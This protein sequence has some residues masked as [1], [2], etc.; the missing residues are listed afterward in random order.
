[1]VFIMNKLSKKISLMITS[2]ILSIATGI[3][4]AL[5][6]SNQALT[7]SSI[8]NIYSKNQATQTSPVIPSEVNDQNANISTKNGPVTFLGNK[9]TALDWFGNK[10][11]E[12]DF[13]TLVPGSQGVNGQSYNGAWPRAWFNWD[14]NR[15]TDT[16][17][18]LGF[19][20]DSTKTQPLFEIKAADGSITNTHT[21]NY[22]NI[23]GLESVKIS[24]AY[25]F[26][27][28]LSSGK[29][30]I[31]GGAGSSY[32]GKAILYDPKTKTASLLNGNSSSTEILPMGDASHGS[33]Y[34]WYFFN[35]IPVAANRNIVEVVT[36]ANKETSNDEGS[37]Y[38]NYHVYFL[39]VD[40]Q[41]N[42]VF[43]SSSS[44]GSQWAKPV[45]V[46]DG[47]QGYRNSKITPQ[48]DYYSLLDGRVVTVVYNT[49]IIIDGKSDNVQVGVYPTSQS[50]WIKS[51]AFDSNQNLYFKFKNEDVIYK[52][53]GSSWQTINNTNTN[54]SPYVYLDLKGISA[55]SAYAQDLIIYNVYGY[56]G[57]LMMINSVYNERVD[58]KNSG[59]TTENNDKNYGLAL[60]V[61]QNDKLQDKGDYKGF[62][63]GPNT[64]QQ[65]SDFELSNSAK[66]SKIPSEITKD[67]IEASNGFLRNSSDFTI[68]EMDD[69]T[70]NI[71]I[72]C[73]LYQI[74]W[75]TD[76]LPDGIS[77]KV[78][79]KTY[80]TDKK[81]IDKTSWKTLTT[82]T[83]YDFLNM[84]PSTIKKEDVENLDPFQ[85]SF[86]SQTI[87]D[88]DGKQLFPKKIYDVKSHDDNQGK[89]TVSINYQ[90]IPMSETYT[91]STTPKTYS[92]EKEYTVFKSSDPSSFKFM[93]QTGTE[94]TI[95]IQKVSELKNLLSAN[96][97]PSS[98]NSLNSSTDKT[99][100]AFLQFINTNTSKGY[101]ISK[102]KFTVTANDTEGSLS[103]KAEM[104]ST[105]SP[106]GQTQTFNIKYTNLNKI[107]S[108]KF[109]FKDVTTIGTQNINTILPSAVTDGD[110][111]NNFISYTGFSSNDFSITKTVDDEKGT[112][113]VAVNLDKKYAQAIGTGNY[114]F[115]NYSATKTFSGFMTKDQYNQRFNVDFVSDSD[116]S[117]LQLKQMQVSKIYES[118]FG[119]KPTDLTV[120]GQ[121]YTNLK[122]LIEKLLIKNKGTSIPD[123]WA[124]NSS[125]TASMH[126]DNAQGT[127]SFYVKIDK[128]LVDGSNSDLNL[129]VNYTGFVKGNVDSTDDNLSFVADNML[130]SYLVSNGDTTADNFKNFT[131]DSFAKWLQENDNQKAL[132]LISYKSGE[133]VTLL[134]DKTKYN[135]SVIPNETQRT[136]S[137]YIY[138]KDVTNPKSLKEYSVTYTI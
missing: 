104:P 56:T 117:L 86:Q 133:Y 98:F 19:W 35:L 31:Y 99:N 82:S 136:V 10:L 7:N 41:L 64:F 100:S 29:V 26:V 61:T 58:T 85:V 105:Y 49:A 63:N 126:Y 97:L 55:A 67:D 59:I 2:S 28:A 72:E 36:F 38:A 91:S 123:S 134:Q 125:I 115:T 37:A 108:Y 33:N 8:T 68:K 113:T 109:G 137:I 46:A 110:I 17:W 129:V 57:Q 48:R 5:P 13:S 40:D 90:Y 127:I 92:A 60:A 32:N 119:S 70:G 112:L 114:G 95:D 138:F 9:I 15:N 135:L 71:K 54:V 76:K 89:V 83:D 65:A 79:S 4:I 52:V 116:N 3:S 103:I 18:V 73:K 118:F 81:I 94:A 27:S 66:T 124:S 16:I 50:K 34:K 96:T 25:R 62:L 93:G 122:D 84:K 106:I 22:K 77:P 14:Y 69:S 24:S 78:I 11:W 42:M 120:D 12:K 6:I 131:P 121:K 107:T 23:S 44:S 111:I 102:M 47:L 53:S 30:M 20:S 45:K 74:P 39:L 101:P 132:K 43:N 130:E 1:M 80:T 51:W 128:L 75:F 21:V 87:V 88:K